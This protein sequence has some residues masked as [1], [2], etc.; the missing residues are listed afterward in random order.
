MLNSYSLSKQ[1]TKTKKSIALGNSLSKVT[2]HSYT[3][4]LRT[5]NSY[6][7]QEANKKFTCRDKSGGKGGCFV[8]TSKSAIWQDLAHPSLCMAIIFFMDE[9]MTIA[10]L[11]HRSQC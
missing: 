10:Q 8:D 7:E 6:S 9:R 2:L 11:I 3:L 4:T 5:K 1:P